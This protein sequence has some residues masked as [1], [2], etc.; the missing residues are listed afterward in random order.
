M[1]TTNTLNPSREARDY[2]GKLRTMPAPK[3]CRLVA[4]Y[5]DGLIELW[6]GKGKRN[7][8]HFELVYGLATIKVA[9]DEIGAARALGEALMHYLRCESKLD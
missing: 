5:G 9:E 1:T 2:T 3:D 8:H 6:Q 7:A 4:V